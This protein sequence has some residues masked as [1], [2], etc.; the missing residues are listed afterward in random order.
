MKGPQLKAI[1]MIVLI[2]GGLGLYILGPSTISIPDL[3]KVKT[4]FKSEEKPATKTK[5]RSA[6][7]RKAGQV[8]DSYKGVDV[9]Y[10][11]NVTNVSGRNTTKDGYN[12][13]LRYQCV[14]FAK[15]F[16][17][18][19]YNH[20]MPDSYG[21]ATDFFDRSLAHGA[22]NKARGMWQFH[23]GGSEKPRANDLAIIGGSASNRFGHL[24]IITEVKHDGVEF[25][26]QNPGVGNPSRGI[27]P[28]NTKNGNWYINADQLVGWLRMK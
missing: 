24:F 22:Y 7:S 17:Y 26:Q 11:G 12:L 2:F 28:L 15:R 5:K 6:G 13:G 20:K 3:S 1:L 9:F 19:A 14:E 16:Y 23:N 8:I 4:W 18:E 25:I 27:Y 21:H 10:N